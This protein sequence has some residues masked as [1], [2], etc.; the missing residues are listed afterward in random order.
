VTSDVCFT[1]SGHL[2]FFEE[3]FMKIDAVRKY[4]LALIDDRSHDGVAKH[5]PITLHRS[6][7]LPKVNYS[8][9]KRQREIAKKKKQ[10]TK[11]AKKMATRDASKSDL[12][13]IAPPCKDA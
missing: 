6:A 11:Q 2:S 5:P 7:T 1:L 8:F 12:G 9:E 13:T 4:T 3:L 10:D